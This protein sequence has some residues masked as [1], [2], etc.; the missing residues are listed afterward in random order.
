MI[1]SLAVIPYRYKYHRYEITS[2]DLA[3]QKGYF[4][5]TTTFVPINR[6]Q[7]VTT[8]Q[9]PILRQQQLMEI[10]VHTAA[11]TH[12][13]AGLDAQE[14]TEL[15]QQIIDLVK[16]AKEDVLKKDVTIRLLSLST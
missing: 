12:R 7:H 2:E 6:I 5:R 9:G 15:R 8:E 16:V 10:A 13:L 4:F 3:F 11:T 14:A 1:F